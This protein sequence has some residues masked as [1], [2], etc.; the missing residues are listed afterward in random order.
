MDPQPWE[1][2][3][4]DTEE[5]WPEFVAYRD[6]PRPRKAY[7]YRPGK[8]NP[9]QVAQWIERHFWRERVAEY[10]RHLD[11]IELAEREALL[12]QS[13]REIAAQHMSLLHDARNVLSAELSKLLATVRASN[14]EVMKPRDLR[15]LLETTV[16]LDRLVR[17][18][19]TERVEEST[20]LSHLSDEDLAKLESLL[21]KGKTD[22]AQSSIH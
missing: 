19:V 18:E 14:L 3:P 5:S 21:T 16:K 20:D 17:G 8:R 15:A 11:A 22:D 13:A 9:I 2:Q 6:S 4:Y 1:R 10:D 7:S 12:A